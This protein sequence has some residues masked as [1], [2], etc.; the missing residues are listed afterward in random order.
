MLDFRS[1]SEDS[2]SSQT[3]AQRILRELVAPPSPGESVKS[4]IR[5]AARYAGLEFR[6]AK[7]LWYGEA[8]AILAEELDH[9][10]QAAAGRTV[11]QREKAWVNE[12]HG[13]A[14]LRDVLDRLERIET[15]LVSLGQN[16]VRS[17]EDRPS[18]Q[19][20]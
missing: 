18:I 8:R 6:R 7:S 5:R 10:R 16:P 17:V 3:E 4:L 13:R 19:R 2:V 12:E 11:K 9:L 1:E 20:D 15:A 14:E